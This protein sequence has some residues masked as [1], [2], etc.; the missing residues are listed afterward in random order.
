MTKKPYKTDI[1]V[2]LLFFTRNDTFQQ[3][4]DAV[5]EARPSRL[6][7]YQDG[8]RN[9][10]DLAGI[11][12]CRKIASDENIDWEC[13]VHRQYLEKNQGCDP[14]G[15]LSH[16][17][18]FSL[19]DKC[20]VLEDDVV[21]SQSFFPFCKEMLDRYEHDERVTMVAG[22][23]T[24]EVTTD[25]PYDYFFTRAFSIWG[26][27]SWSRV[28]NNWD[29]EYSFVKDPEKFS[30]LCGKVE[31]YHQRKDMPSMCQWHANSGRQYFESIFWAYMLLHDGLA[32][33]PS[34]NM[35]NNIGMNEGT[36]YSTQLDLMPK[37]LRRIFTM[38]KYEIDF[39]LSHPTE[40]KEYPDYQKRYYLV[41][42][43]NNPWRKVQYSIE[44][45]WLNI[46]QGNWQNISKS[47]RRRICKWMGNS[48]S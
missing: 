5:R 28:V 34:K 18:A 20:I 43:W 12:A 26:W 38:G 29:G 47:L 31:Q 21:P 13:E 1:A 19:A 2:L 30:E 11:E 35:I 42:A 16:R 33:M 3:V 45:L 8:P 4:F 7:L 10:R 17:W 40:V 23:N 37:R 6:F 48:H 22:F 46:K 32:I 24:D 25:M 27:A 15:F 36:H 14:S 9:E 41:N 39:P 44:E